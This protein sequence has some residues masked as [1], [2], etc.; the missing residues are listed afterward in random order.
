MDSSESNATS[1]IPVKN[2]ETSRNPF[3]NY[4]IEIRQNNPHLLPT[5]A[6]SLAAIQ[7]KIMPKNA[8][9]RYDECAKRARYVYKSR[10]KSLN[11]VL[12]YLRRAT[13]HPCKIEP[14][15]VL[16]AS[17]YLKRWKLRVFRNLR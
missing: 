14:I 15:E 4:L 9:Q 2:P 12:R 6:V 10:N 17:K 5:Q 8:R 3:I 13:Q 7:W 1:E 16:N 11:R